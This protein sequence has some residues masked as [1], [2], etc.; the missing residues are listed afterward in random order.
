MDI[1]W[2]PPT[3]LEDV[4]H[5]VLDNYFD[6]KTIAI[7]S[8]VSRGINSLY[9]GSP[10]RAANDIIQACDKKHIYFYRSHGGNV[11]NMIGEYKDGFI[12]ICLDIHGDLHLFLKAKLPRVHC[13]TALC[14]PEGL[15]FLR[16]IKKIK[17][18]VDVRVKRLPRM[19]GNL[20]IHMTIIAED[21]IK[22]LHQVKCGE[23]LK[24][25]TSKMSKR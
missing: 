4:P 7:L 13:M 15:E 6:G 11:I 14:D 8:M 10:S 21:I 24:P 22:K 25:C 18:A 23:S 16:A 1:E 20:D 19:K 2:K 12:Q 9:K 5:L 3:R 17:E